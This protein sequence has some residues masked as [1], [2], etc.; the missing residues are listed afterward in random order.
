MIFVMAV[1]YM[2]EAVFAIEHVR[3]WL[4]RV[5]TK[6]ESTEHKPLE[7]D[8]ADGRANVSKDDPSS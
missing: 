7:L 3:L 8:F 5:A 1:Y 4:K 2:S 6:G